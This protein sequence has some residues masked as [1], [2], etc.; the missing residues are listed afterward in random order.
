MGL[1]ADGVGVGVGVGAGVVGVGAGVVGDDVAGDD[2]GR[3]ADRDSL[4]DGG[5]LDAH[6]AGG[7]GKDGR[8]EPEPD[9]RGHYGGLAAG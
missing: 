6:S 7:R 2:E 5:G 3:G 1:A 8:G 9:A 4:P